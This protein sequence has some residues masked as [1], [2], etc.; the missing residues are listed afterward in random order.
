LTTLA[1]AESTD[2]AGEAFTTLIDEVKAG[3]VEVNP[4]YGTLRLD[5]LTPNTLFSNLVQGNG[6]VLPVIQT[7]PDWLVPLDDQ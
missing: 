6:A 7:S 4:R 5:E 3:G 2:V 1:T